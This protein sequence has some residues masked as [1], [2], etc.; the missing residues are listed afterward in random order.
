[1]SDENEPMSLADFAGTTTADPEVWEL[2][3]YVAGKTARSVA[4]FENL[5]QQC[6]VTLRQPVPELLRR[7]PLIRR[8]A[9]PG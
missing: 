6:R 5:L 8:F 4:A 7:G 9:R 3:L 1:M 2:R